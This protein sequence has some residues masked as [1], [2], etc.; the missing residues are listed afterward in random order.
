MNLVCSRSH[1]LSAISIVSQF[2]EVT[3]L[4]SSNTTSTILGGTSE[5]GACQ[6]LAGVEVAKPG[7]TAIPLGLLRNWLTQSAAEN[8][9][10]IAKDDGSVSVLGTDCERLSFVAPDLPE[11]EVPAALS[12]NTIQVQTADFRQALTR[13]IFAAAKSPRDARWATNAVK[14]ELNPTELLLA[15][16]D[17]IQLATA[18]LDGKGQSHS[19]A[20]VPVDFVKRFTRSRPI[21]EKITISVWASGIRLQCGSLDSWSHTISRPF[22]KLVPL[23]QTHSCEIS[24]AEF[25]RAIRMAI[26]GADPEPEDEMDPAF[27]FVTVKLRAGSLSVRGETAGDST[28]SVVEMELPQHKGPGLEVT[29]DGPRLVS[30]LKAIPE[31]EQIAM[32]WSKNGIA[33]EFS[34]C[35]RALFETSGKSWY[36]TAPHLPRSS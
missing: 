31:T 26:T 13:V 3:G 30:Y 8:V 7:E 23:T 15:A 16:T 29:L 2:S 10:V 34:P 4:L 5:F 35:D 9:R 6:T 27:R 32:K 19:E 14:F 18:T 20:L 25:L 12:T 33:I 21:E 1:L 28:S 22:P 24:R 36:L 17:E 11:A